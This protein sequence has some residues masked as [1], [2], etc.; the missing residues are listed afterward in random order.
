MSKMSSQAISRLQGKVLRQASLTS[1]KRFSHTR[2]CGCRKKWREVR[3]MVVTARDERATQK[4]RTERQ[5]EVSVEMGAEGT[6][7]ILKS[8]NPVLYTKNGTVWIWI[9]VWGRET[10][11]QQCAS[12]KGST[13]KA[14]KG[15]S[16]AWKISC[17]RWALEK[18]MVGLFGHKLGASNKPKEVSPYYGLRVENI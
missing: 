18:E 13:G 8:I 12:Q 4:V 10:S 17:Q 16:A 5:S 14:R 6:R 9:N 15:A 1:G 2:E 3:N 7:I 11:L